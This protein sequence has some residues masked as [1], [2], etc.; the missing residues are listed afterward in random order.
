MAPLPSG[1]AAEKSDLDSSDEEDRQDKK[2]LNKM[3]SKLNRLCN[4]TATGKLQ[5]SEDLHNMW[6]QKGKV[7]DDLVQLMA[8][9]GGNRA[10]RIH[11]C[12]VMSHEYLNLAYL[13]TYRV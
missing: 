4:R 2:F 7:R 5:V 10:T 13:S 6:L 9:A 11:I 3:R 1:Q 12:R 8:D